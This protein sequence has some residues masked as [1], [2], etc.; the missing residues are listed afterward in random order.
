SHWLAWTRSVALDKQT[1][2]ESSPAVGRDV[3]RAN[4]PPDLTPEDAR[5]TRQCA[6]HRTHVEIAPEIIDLQGKALER[7]DHAHSNLDSLRSNLPSLAPSEHSDASDAIRP[8]IEH[9]APRWLDLAVSDPDRE[10]LDWH[11]LRRA[12][13]LLCAE[14]ADRC[15]HLGDRLTLL[16]TP[17]ALRR[18]GR[19]WAI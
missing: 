3:E 5:T 18:P 9:H 7:I 6:A 2:R 1:T 13:P 12:D 8:P 16:A 4:L 10:H 11:C 19:H 14:I 15:R 17:H